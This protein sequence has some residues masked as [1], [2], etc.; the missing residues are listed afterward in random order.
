M[1]GKFD[2]KGD[3]WIFLGYCIKIKSYKLLNKRTN[4]IIR[5][6]SVKVDEFSEKN[7]EDNMKKLEGYYELI[8]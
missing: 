1:N 6:A 2:T 7:E 3:E 4:K 5:S 8:Y